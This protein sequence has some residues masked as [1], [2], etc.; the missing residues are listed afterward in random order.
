MP[1]KP[2]KTNHPSMP[3]TTPANNKNLVDLAQCETIES[4]MPIKFE[5][6]GRIM[7]RFEGE[8]IECGEPLDAAFIKGRVNTYFAGVAI[9]E[10]AGICPQCNHLSD[11][12]TRIREDGSF[13]IRDESG[14][15][16]EIRFTPALVLFAFVLKAAAIT[17]KWGKR[18]LFK[19]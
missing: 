4:Q 16:Q 11:L 5:R 13:A 17:K 9:I 10:A 14:N 2:Q 1:E 8:C 19:P 3:Y 12:S 7:N 18:L 15:W 6:T